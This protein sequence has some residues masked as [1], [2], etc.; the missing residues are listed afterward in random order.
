MI[1]YPKL[2]QHGNIEQFQIYLGKV[3]TK[4]NNNQ[5]VANEIWTTAKVVNNDGEATYHWYGPIVFSSR[6]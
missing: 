2:I 1:G 3:A 5:L 4:Y 6:P